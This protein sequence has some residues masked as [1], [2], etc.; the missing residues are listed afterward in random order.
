MILKI[1]S[2]IIILTI[3]I[4]FI[5][6]QSVMPPHC[7]LNGPQCQ[8]RSIIDSTKVIPDLNCIKIHSENCGYQTIKLSNNCN[9]NITFEN[10]KIE[11]GQFLEFIINN[12][13]TVIEVPLSTKFDNNLRATLFTQI[14]NKSIE[15]YKYPQKKVKHSS[16][17]SYNKTTYLITYKQTSECNFWESLT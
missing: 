13:E 2:S 17:F 5:S 3:I 1:I 12:N 6:Y 15:K 10:Y 9:S 7:T 11:P 8:A 16:N 14:N 4:F